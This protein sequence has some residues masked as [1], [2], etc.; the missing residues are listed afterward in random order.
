MTTCGRPKTAPWLLSDGTGSIRIAAAA[1]FALLAGESVTGV[2]ASQL[3]S[4]GTLLRGK[5]TFSKDIAPLV[6]QHCAPCHRPGQ[7]APFSLLTYDDAKRHAHEIV[8][9]TQ[10]RSMPPWLPE[11]GHGE[12]IGERR[13]TL[14]QIDLLRQWAVGGALEGDPAEL[15]PVPTWKSGWQLGAPDLVVTLPQRYQ[16]RAEGRDVY[17]NFVIPI[18]LSAARYVEAIEFDPGNARVVHHAFMQFDRTR[19]SRKLDERDAE[20][21]FDGLHPPTG[22]E[23]AAGHFLSWQPGKLAARNPSGLAWTLEKDADLVLQMHLKPSGKIEEVRPSVGFYFTDRAPTNRAFKVGL[24]SFAID[25]PA[26]QS[27]YQLEDEYVVPAAVRLLALLPHAHYLGREMRVTAAFPNGKT[28]SLLFIRQWD[29]NWQGEYRY[30]EPVFLPQGTK[31]TMRYTYDNSTNN[32]RNP[33]QPPRRVQYGVQATDEMG[34]LW[35]QLLPNSTNDLAILEREDYPR[36]IQ[37]SIAFS[38]YALRLNPKDARAHYELGKALYAQRERDEAVKHLVQAA[39]LDP[40]FDE[41][42]YFLGVMLRRQQKPSQARSAFEEAL[43]RN[44]DNFKAHGNLGFIFVDLGQLDSA[45]QHFRTALRINPDDDLAKSGLEEI[46][47]ARR[48]RGPSP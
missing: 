28:Q 47:H 46:V 25:I 12:F 16:L 36:A 30:R 32:I 17:R 13:L 9:V 44:P 15:P 34:E 38:Q 31:V 43:R 10:S 7:A 1:L 4:T 37:Q 19:Q 41:P 26:G 42:P 40:A 48:R 21:G 20:P 11:P 18:P 22:A 29:L 39:D 5:P 6:F 8:E 35:L 23:I 45:E 3:D 2:F 33:H 27:D 14:S 24:R